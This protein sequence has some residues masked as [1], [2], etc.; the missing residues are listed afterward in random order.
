[1]DAASDYQTLS[2]YKFLPVLYF[3]FILKNS[4][5]YFAF[6]QRVKGKFISVPKQHAMKIY[7]GC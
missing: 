2:G 1:M 4:L 5:K 7:R 6:P 3:V